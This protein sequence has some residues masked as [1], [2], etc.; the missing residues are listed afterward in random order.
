MDEL[1]GSRPTVVWIGHGAMGK[2]MSSLLADAG[3]DVISIDFRKVAEPG[4]L[5]E[6]L[7][8]VKY[9]FTC[10]PGPNDVLSTWKELAVLLQPGATLIDVSTIGPATAVQLSSLAY[11]SGHQA[12]DCPVSGGPSGAR[13]G[14]LVVMVGGS[15]AALDHVKPLLERF[16]TIIHCGES[17]AGQRMKLINQIVLA[18]T[19]GGLGAGFEAARSNGLDTSLVHDVLSRGVNRGFLLDA[20]WP[21]M[22]RQAHDEGFKATHLMKDIDL[23]INEVL[24]SSGLS[25]AVHREVHCWLARAVERSGENVA[26]QAIHLG[27]RSQDTK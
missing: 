11:G 19:L 26:T 13:T 6:Q 9:A 23:A 18:A 25:A 17:G 27:V 4:R 1:K 21:Q 20:L 15:K 10:L 24:N 16:G 22:Q 8:E 5:R 7:A 3:H 12:L 14:S 2:P